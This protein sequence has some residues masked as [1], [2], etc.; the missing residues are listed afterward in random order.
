LDAAYTTTLAAD[1]RR[2][3]EEMV[4]LVEGWFDT[5]QLNSGMLHTTIG[6]DCVQHVNGMNVSAGDYWAAQVA[7][8]CLAQLQQGLFKPVDRIRARRYP[9]VIEETGVVVALSLE[10]HATRYVDYTSV[11]GAP[12]KV[13]VEYPNTRGRLELF[14]LRD[15]AIERVD[16][17]S[18]FLPYYIAS[19]WE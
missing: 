5:R 2:S 6:Q 9:V 19:L 3:R 15:G 12:L 17:I 8:G 16:G 13:E 7:Q 14:R 4:A 10:D 1:E 11:E 18:V